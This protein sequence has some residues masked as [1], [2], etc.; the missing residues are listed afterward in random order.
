MRRLS[1]IVSSLSLRRGVG[2]THIPAP[3]AGPISS[4]SSSAL[5]L[6][7]TTSQEA[8]KVKKQKKKQK[9][10]AAE[11]KREEKEEKRREEERRLSDQLEE[12][13]LEQAVDPSGSLGELA[14]G[15]QDA[16]IAAVLQA[17]RKL[18]SSE[19]SQ[20]SPPSGGDE[21]M[22]GANSPTASL[23]QTD[24][25]AEGDEVDRIG[26]V[27]RELFLRCP[28]IAAQ[29]DKSK[30]KAPLES[31]TYDSAKIV[32]WRCG[33]CNHRWTKS[34]IERCIYNLPCPKCSEIRDPKLGAV[35][36]T[37]SR[38]WDPERNDPFVDPERISAKSIQKAWW[39]CSACKGSFEGKVR[40][41][42]TGKCKCPS[43]ALLGFRSDPQREEMLRQE[44]H[45]T[46]NGDLQRE[47]LRM[48]DHKK[49]WWLCSTCGREWEA[50]LS[51]R[52]RRADNTVSRGADCPFCAQEKK[53]A[54]KTIAE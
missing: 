35:A 43:C 53:S 13:Q 21:I 7:Q 5:L 45:P 17:V 9:N 50:M 23:F 26:P 47:H 28:E 1:L 33:V 20:F 22:S 41:R 51:T 42:V 6:K 37:I 49:V 16:P 46:R 24:D 32:N 40:D 54:A 19:D 14:T 36:P 44:W 4:Y 34:I 3:I 12:I 11:K 27:S 18:G 31:L 29:Y 39:M 2:L 15:R 8:R 48:S 25:A 30:N 10:R 38:E 52:L